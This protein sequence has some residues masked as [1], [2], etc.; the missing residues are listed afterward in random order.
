MQNIDGIIADSLPDTSVAAKSNSVTG[1][2]ET[3]TAM[4]ARNDRVASICGEIVNIISKYLPQ[5]ANMQVVTDTGVL[6]G[7]M[8]PKIDKILG[9][10]GN[11][12]R[13]GMYE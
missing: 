7:Q 5:M 6:A 2:M 10:I 8:A 12:K 11:N 4:S 9:G 13:R 1:M 3:I